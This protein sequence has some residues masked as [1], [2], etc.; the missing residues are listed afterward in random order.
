M[1]KFMLVLKIRKKVDDLI[2]DACSTHEAILHDKNLS[3]F[4]D[5]IPDDSI[6]EARY[7][8]EEIDDDALEV[9]NTE[10]INKKVE[11]NSCLN[12][13]KTIITTKLETK[14]VLHNVKQNK[15]KIGISSRDGMY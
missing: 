10:A 5:N 13:I 8:I 3:Q 14:R 4:I 2:K 7:T 9:E 6:S 11:H 1:V 12:R 15:R